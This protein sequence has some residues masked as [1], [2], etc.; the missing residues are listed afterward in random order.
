[1]HITYLANTYLD[2]DKKI[3][4]DSKSLSRL[5][6]GSISNKID[7]LLINEKKNLDDYTLAHLLKSLDTINE[8]L[9][10]E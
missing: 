2:E 6:L 1:M 9:D 4:Y 7:Y 10:K 8:L 3:P 5:H